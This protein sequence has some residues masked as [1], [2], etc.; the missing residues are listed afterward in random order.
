MVPGDARARARQA[1]GDPS[2]DLVAFSSATGRRLWARAVSGLR[3]PAPRGPSADVAAGGDL[4]GDGRAES[5]SPDSG[6]PRP[7]CE[8]YQGLRM[9][10]GATGQTRWVRP[11]RGPT[12]TWPQT[13]WPRSDRRPRSRW[14]R[15]P[16]PRGGLPLRRPEP[17]HLLH[18]EPARSDAGLRRRALRQGRPSALVVARGCDGLRPRPE[19]G[20]R[21]G[22]A[23]GPTAGRCW[24][25]RSAARCRREADPT[26][27]LSTACR[28]WSASWKPRRAARCTR[29]TA[30][31]GPGSPI[32]TATA[33]RISGARSTAS[34]GR[35]VPSRR[36]RGG[37][38]TN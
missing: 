32:S 21:S 24:W 6:R 36:R 4:D 2:N 27:P 17:R 3:I 37:A 12:L 29:S 7:Q 8:D 14:R 35:S 26:S 31:P 11:H 38:S 10:E 34:S 16:R 1:A 19:S 33:S 20:R 18:G 30:C 5:W 13:A 15:H 23:A 25:S 28:R 22:G 9:L